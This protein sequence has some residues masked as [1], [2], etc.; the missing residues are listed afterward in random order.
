MQL[1]TIGHHPRTGFFNLGSLDQIILCCDQLISTIEDV[2][3]CP[4][5]LSINASFSLIVEEAKICHGQML[6]RRWNCPR[7][8]I[9][10]GFSYGSCIVLSQLR[11][12]KANSPQNLLPWVALGYKR[13]WDGIL[14][15]APIG[16][17]RSLFSAEYKVPWQTM[18]IVIGYGLTL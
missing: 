7:G 4:W 9:L 13:A 11:K 17:A 8:I 6:P 2:I 10:I 3:H 18:L 12:A 15:E 1:L 14:D 16:C 5:F